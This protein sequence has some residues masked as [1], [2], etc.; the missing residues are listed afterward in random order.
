MACQRDKRCSSTREINMYSYVMDPAPF[1][2]GECLHKERTVAEVGH[3][4]VAA[5]NRDAAARADV[6]SALRYQDSNSCNLRPRPKGVLRFDSC[7]PFGDD[8]RGTRC[9]KKS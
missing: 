8:A 5:G 4:L 3:G 1:V 6:S 2:H 9:N 7:A